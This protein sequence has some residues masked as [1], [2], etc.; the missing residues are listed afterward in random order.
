MCSPQARQPHRPAA[1]CGCGPHLHGRHP[2]R[3]VSRPAVTHEECDRPSGRQEA[4]SGPSGAWGAGQAVT[5]QPGP[6]VHAAVGGMAWGG[7]ITPET[8]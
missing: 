6:P 4:Q 5:R 2:V 3:G 8:C 7:G 1:D